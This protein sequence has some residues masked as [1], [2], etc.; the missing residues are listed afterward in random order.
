M[1]LIGGVA[2]KVNQKQDPAKL[3][4]GKDY[5]GLLDWIKRQAVVFFDTHERR[6]W[7]VDGAS[8]L[9][10]LVRTSLHHDRDDEDSTFD[11]KSGSTDLKDTWPGSTMRRAAV[12]TLKN[13]YNVNLPLYIRKYGE[14]GQPDV[15]TTFQDRVL[16]ILHFL[17]ILVET[18][19]CEAEK[20][21]IKIRQTKDQRTYVTGYD[22]LDLLSPRPDVRS[23]IAH[24][25]T[26]GDGWMDL[27]RSIKALTL[28]GQGYG[29]LVRPKDSSSVCAHWKTVPMQKD[30]M[31]ASIS[32][33][34]VLRDEWSRR[35]GSTSDVSEFR[36]GLL[37]I[38]R[39]PP[40]EPCRCLENQSLEKHEHVDPRQFFKKA[41]RSAWQTPLTLKASAPIDFD[42]MRETAPTG[43]VVFANLG[44][45][46]RPISNA[47]DATRADT[48]DARTPSSLTTQTSA[49]I[50]TAASVTTSSQSTADATST[51]T[52][53]TVPGTDPPDPEFPHDT[54]AVK[55][56]DKGKRKLIRDLFRRK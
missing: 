44:L 28:F 16:A 30:Y 35:D 43:A 46:N 3:S 41:S 13:R 18:Q 21:D 55:K 8:A 7:L 54:S 26:W 38:S 52:G 29:D 25:D 19:S 22:V 6:A 1:H 31:C 20:G 2:L 23:R 47:K 51:I 15:Y 53:V 50:S 10:H 33:L 12:E 39:F 11:W 37:W 40:F 32:T 24:F 4:R 5:Q 36:S 56:K 45:L 14:D 42:K 34:R 17:E 27:L 49:S 9:L 48:K